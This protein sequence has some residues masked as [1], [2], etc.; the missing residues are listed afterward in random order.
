MYIS[1]TNFLEKL[2]SHQSDTAWL[3]SLFEITQKLLVRY[4]KKLSSQKVLRAIDSIDSSLG[5]FLTLLTT[6]NKLSL[7][8]T[9]QFLS[10]LKKNE[11]NYKKQ[12]IV[13]SST[14]LDTKNLQKDLL[15]K[16][17]NC[18]IETVSTPELELKIKG[19]W[20]VYKRS[21]SLDLDKLL[22]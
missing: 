17:G 14:Q 16:I 20:Y 8:T 6:Y 18:E 12:L 2:Q 11:E 3:I 13:S 15:K 9:K 10:L 22:A 21:L 19:D 5:N 4:G 7:R 1:H